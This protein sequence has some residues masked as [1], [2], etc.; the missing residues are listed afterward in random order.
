MQ[1]DRMPKRPV[2]GEDDR[3][4]VETLADMLT[5]LE[6]LKEL[7]EDIKAKENNAPNKN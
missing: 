3:D 4:L 2:A 1:Q 7:V 5:T 6:K